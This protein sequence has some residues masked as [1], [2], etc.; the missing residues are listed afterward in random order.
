MDGNI[1]MNIRFSTVFVFLFLTAV[2]LFGS[3]GILADTDLLIS[4]TFDQDTVGAKPAGYVIEETGG[5][6]EIVDLTGSGNKSLGLLDPG[7]SNIKVIKSRNRDLRFFL[8]S[9][10]FI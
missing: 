4:D 9:I 7:T 8:S 3:F 5:K 6:V 1:K 2:M 10:Y